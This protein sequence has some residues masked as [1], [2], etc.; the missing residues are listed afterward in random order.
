L[1]QGTERKKKRERGEGEEAPFLSE[2]TRE[3]R[4]TLPEGHKKVRARRLALSNE[5]VF[6]G[7]KKRERTEGGGGIGIC[8]R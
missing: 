1:A 4:R 8:V 5:E 6:S 3:K 2:A 7:G